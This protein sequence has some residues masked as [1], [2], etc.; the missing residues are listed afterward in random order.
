MTKKLLLITA[1]LLSGF[2]FGQFTTGL[3]QVTTGYSV[4]IDTD[5]T[6]V[7]ATLVGPSTTW[8]G[9]GFGGSDMGS[10]NDI[11]AYNSSANRDYNATGT[12]T[13]AADA[14]QSWTTVSDNDSGGIRTFVATRPLVSA[15]DYTFVNSTSSIPIIWAQGSALNFAYHANRSAATL[16]RTQI[17]STEDFSLNAT[18]I[19]PNPSK[20]AFNVRTKTALEKIDIYTQTG[21]LVRSIDVKSEIET[22][23]NI[24]GLAT[25]IYL[26]ELQN[27]TDKSWKKIVVE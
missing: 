19:Y 9:M 27:K 2:S 3:V 21:A 14:A 16:T 17:L 22:Q 18:S 26:I 24:E 4:R 12:G 10:A 6:M 13:P 1:L 20:G 23:V 25:G 11:L 5:A 8:L 7:V 15:G